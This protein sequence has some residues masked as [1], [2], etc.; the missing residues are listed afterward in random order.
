MFPFNCP[1]LECLRVTGHDHTKNDLS[2]L[3]TLVLSSQELKL[4]ALDLQYT[5]EKALLLS[6]SAIGLLARCWSVSA[7]ILHGFILL[8]GRDLINLVK[9]TAIKVVVRIRRD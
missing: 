4:K 2:E 6:C 5:G 1:S 8:D 7:L 3:L 9:T